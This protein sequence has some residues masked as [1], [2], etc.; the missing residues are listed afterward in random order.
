VT[1]KAARQ[2]SVSVTAATSGGAINAPNEVPT[3]KKPT[4]ID[5]CLSESHS[6]TAFMRRCH[7]DRR[8]MEEGLFGALV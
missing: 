2:P 7:V 5:F 4:A 8:W 6:A 1:T 3:L